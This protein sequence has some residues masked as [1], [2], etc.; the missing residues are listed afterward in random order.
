MAV[1]DRS[2]ATGCV[3]MSRSEQL[4]TDPWHSE[5]STDHPG[6]STAPII[7]ASVNH[8]ITGSGF[9]PNHDVT[10]RVTYSAEDVDDYLTYTTDSRGNLHAE[11]P[12][13]PAA[14]PLFIQATDHRSDP[15]GACG[16][17]WSNIQTVRTPGPPTSM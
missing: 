14:G 5:S 7:R 1:A 17:L 9:L 8:A 12:A 15:A 10:L 16:L 13:S 3:T 4:V 11:L 6:A 2:Q